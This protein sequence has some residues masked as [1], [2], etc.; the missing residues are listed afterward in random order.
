MNFTASTL[1]FILAVTGIIIP[2][3]LAAPHPAGK[4]LIGLARYRSID[5]ATCRVLGRRGYANRRRRYWLEL[6]VRDRLLKPDLV[7]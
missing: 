1:A 7:E 3:A 5:P 2:T 6:R 4:D